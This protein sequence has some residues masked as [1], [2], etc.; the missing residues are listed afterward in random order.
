MIEKSRVDWTFIKI[1]RLRGRQREKKRQI[2]ILK[3]LNGIFFHIEYFVLLAKILHKNEA[4]GVGMTVNFFLQKKS[5]LE[6]RKSQVNFCV[7][8]TQK[9]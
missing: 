9:M 7:N 5:F 3:K 4:Y 8:I 6:Y 1:E 2:V